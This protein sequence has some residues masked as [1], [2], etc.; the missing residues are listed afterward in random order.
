MIEKN[1]KAA[2]ESSKIIKTKVKENSEKVENIIKNSLNR[3]SQKYH[4]DII[5]ILGAIKISF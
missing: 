4:D 5:N 3:I 1:Y 2:I